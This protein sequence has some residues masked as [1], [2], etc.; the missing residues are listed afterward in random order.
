MTQQKGSSGLIGHYSRLLENQGS[1]FRNENLRRVVLTYIQKGSVLDAGC[2]TGHLALRLL[3]KGH[4]VV[5]IDPEPEMVSLTRKL[6]SHRGF[7]ADV[8]QGDICTW[9]AQQGPPGR[10][11]NIVCIDVLEHIE[12]DEMA[13]KQLHEQLNDQGRLI[14][15]VPAFAKLHGRRDRRIG[16]WRRYDKGTLMTRLHSLGYQVIAKRYWGI[17]GLTIYFVFEKLFKREVK[18]DFRYSVRGR[19]LNQ[20]LSWWYRVIENHLRPPFGLSLIVI[21]CRKSP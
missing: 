9:Q 18:E 4:P 16:H 13:L 3:E 21:A 1:D 8:F 17:L 5:C 12:D 10:F 2:G 6:L 7:N 20:I 11:D 15:V 19:W 14:L